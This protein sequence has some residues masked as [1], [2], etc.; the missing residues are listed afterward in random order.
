MTGPYFQSGTTITGFS[1]GTNPSNTLTYKYWTINLSK[2]MILP[3]SFTNLTKPIYSP[4]TFVNNSTITLTTSRVAVFNGGSNQY[5]ANINGA[6]SLVSYGNIT[7]K[8]TGGRNSSVNV[9]A[10]YSNSGSRGYGGSINSYI[11]YDPYTSY[12]H[13][14]NSTL[15]FFNGNNLTAANTLSST[16]IAAGYSIPLQKL[17]SGAYGNFPGDESSGYY[18]G[19]DL[20]K[21]VPGAVVV[22]F[23]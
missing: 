20:I 23:K 1:L 14:N 2:P 22:Y 11:N 19:G 16:L 12:I 4:I 6:D 3:R 7:I 8:A 5:Y 18:P 10:E 13:F 21:A 17:G 15:L 9:S